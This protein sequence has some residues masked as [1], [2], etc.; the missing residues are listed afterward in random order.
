MEFIIN[1][2]SII[3]HVDHGKTTLL[4]YLINFCKNYKNYKKNFFFINNNLYTIKF[5]IFTAILNKKIIN[6]IDCPGHFDFINEIYK[7]ILISDYCLI[8][9]DSLKGIEAQTIFCYN[10]SKKF[11]KKIILVINKIDIY[12][13]LKK[14]KQKIIFFKKKYKTFF[15]SS[16]YKTGVLK[17]FFLR[18]K[19]KYINKKLIF[20]FENLNNIKYGNIIF[21]KILTGTIIYG[22]C[23]KNK[24]NNNILLSKI[25]I[26]SVKNIFLKK[27]FN[28]CIHFCFSNKIDYKKTHF[29]SCYNNNLYFNKFIVNI[30]YNLYMQQNFFLLKLVTNDSS[31]YFETMNSIFFGESYFLGFIGVL[32]SEIFF[33]KLSLLSRFWVTNPIIFFLF[34][35]NN[36]WIIDKIFYENC[37]EYEQ[38]MIVKLYI[39][40]KNF[41]FIIQNIFFF[42]YY[43]INI[44]NYSNLIVIT[45]YINLFKIINNFFID[46]NKKINGFIFY[47]FSFHNFHK[48]NLFFLQ[49]SINNNLLNDFFLVFENNIKDNC[50][51]FFNKLKKNL[52]KNIFDI[53]VQFIYRKK[54]IFTKKISCYKK[55]VLDKCYGGDI[56]RKMKLLNKQKIGKKNMKTNINLNNKIIINIIKNE[57]SNI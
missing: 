36:K 56:T 57:F 4:N 40:K 42:N 14:I 24:Y 30:Y 12:V 27:T 55:N 37:Y 53:K 49:I 10:L 18:K 31:I 1:N 7:S 26:L 17:I 54:I 9:I 51:L 46:L 50:N 29:Y 39:L 25:G 13:K 34:N 33:K 23:L 3:A 15:I 8:I 21:F 20:I 32:H 48:S 11:N 19:I 5:N 2:I 44:N 47:E 45:F 35:K 16:K 22:N 38:I 41:F 28:N 43:K 52:N 6:F